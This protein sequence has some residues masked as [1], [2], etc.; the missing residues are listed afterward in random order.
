MTFREWIFSIHPE[1]DGYSGQ[2][3]FPHIF[4]LCLCIALIVAIALIFRK[5][6]KNTREGV[7]KTLA[8]LILIFE[9]SRRVINFAK[10]SATDFNS[11][12]YLLLPR[13]WCAISCWLLIVSAVF[14][15]KT[16]WNFSAINALLCAIIFFAYPSAGFNDKHILFE[17]L[18]SISTHALLLISSISILT[19]KIGDF[20]YKRETFKQ[21]ILK[22]IILL[23]CVFAYAFIEIYLLNIAT[24][25]LYF[26]PNN[27]VQEI[28]GMGYPVYVI[29]YVLFLCVWVNAFYLIPLLWKKY[30]KKGVVEEPQT[31]TVKSGRYLKTK[32][33]TQ[34]KKRKRK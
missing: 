18:Y 25:P 27:E 5:K 30:V 19:L 33:E 8:V 7:L 11:T 23:A 32:G 21:G 14:N 9:I 29:V 3:K 31:Q 20:R 12:M 24:D 2:W 26:M 10:G 15:K 1:G 6:S 4:T 13:P 34:T 28:L 22:E 17:N 16:L